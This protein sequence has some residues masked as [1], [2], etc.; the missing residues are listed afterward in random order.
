MN[1]GRQIRN[2]IITFLI[3]FMAAAILPGCVSTKK[4]TSQLRG[5]MLQDNLQMK[6]NR[7]YYSKHNIKT[8]KTAYRRYRKYNR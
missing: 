3:I 7:A 1:R 2:L 5:L 4:D 6:R 8:K